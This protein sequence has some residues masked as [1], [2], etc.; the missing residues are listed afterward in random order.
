[1]IRF[2]F[3]L[4]TARL[5]SLLQRQA[6]GLGTDT[7]TLFAFAAYELRVL[8]WHSLRHDMGMGLYGIKAIETWKLIKIFFFETVIC[9]WIMGN[10]IAIDDSFQG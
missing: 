10:W 2:E 9:S 5:S 8:V 4:Q 3:T 1:M 7:E 6:P